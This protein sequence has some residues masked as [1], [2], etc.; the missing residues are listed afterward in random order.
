M[1]DDSPVEP[2]A[3]GANN[4]GPNRY[5]FPIAVIVLAVLGVIAL[6]M[7][8]NVDALSPAASRLAKFL[9]PFLA[10]VIIIGVSLIALSI[11]FLFFS[12]LSRRARFG[13]AVVVVA[14]FVAL[15]AAFK[16]EGFTGDIV[17]RVRA[18]WL[19]APSCRKPAKPEPI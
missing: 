9:T 18:R 8:E 15:S 5:W 1:S 3:P 12:P 16:I 6:E 13:A 14:A 11:W 7:I 19:A 4:A 17:P 10:R 2:G